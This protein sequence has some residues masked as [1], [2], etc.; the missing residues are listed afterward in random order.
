VQRAQSRYFSNTTRN[1][2]KVTDRGGRANTKYNAQAQ[3]AQ[4]KFLIDKA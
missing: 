4:P 2:Y 3:I 1:V